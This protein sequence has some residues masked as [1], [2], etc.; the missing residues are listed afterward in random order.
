VSVTSDGTTWSAPSS[1]F[2]P[3]VILQFDDGSIGTLCESLPVSAASTTAYGATSAAISF[4]NLFTPPYTCKVDQIAAWVSFTSLSNNGVLELTDST[5]AILASSQFNGVQLGSATSA[6]RMVVRPITETI[7]SPGTSYYKGFRALSGTTS[8]TLIAYADVA[9]S[10]HMGL[11][12]SGTTC[13]ASS[14]SSSSAAPAAAT[15]TRRYM[16]FL[17]VSAISDNAGSAGG[18]L[19][20]P[21]MGGRL[22]G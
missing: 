18:L 8:G 22:L 6:T 9:S 3:D 2:L 20:H 12:P 21:G 17:R 13:L 14:R 5:G 19:G 4:G 7:L 11:M 15:N 1:I 10:A 16:T